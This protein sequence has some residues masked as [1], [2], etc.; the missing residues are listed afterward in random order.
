MNPARQL[1]DITPRLPLEPTASVD[2]VYDRER[3]ALWYYMA[4]TPRPC[5]NPRLLQRIREFQNA[6]AARQRE[7]GEEPVRY[8]VAASRIPGIW[9]LGGDLSLFRRLI[10]TRDRDGLL[11]YARACIDV[12]YTN[13]VGFGQ[14]VTTISLVQGDALGGGFEAAISSHVLV[15]ERGARLGFPEVLFNLFPGM[16]AYNLLSRRLDPHRAEKIIT[17]GKLYTA[18][19]LYDLEVVDV[20][21]QPGEGDAAVIDYIRQEN[22]HRNGLRAFR[23]ARASEHPLT[24]RELMDGAVIWVDAALRLEQRDLRMMDRLVSRQSAGAQTRKSPDMAS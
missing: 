19:E 5:F 10:T 1:I 18:E 3:E 2:P 20:L 9:N 21:A 22:R 16:G 8:I 7:P 6:V 23:A 13:A 11:R 14:D 24:H 17:S 12:L 15:A 4:A